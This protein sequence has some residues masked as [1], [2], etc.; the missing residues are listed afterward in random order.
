[1]IGPYYIYE[2][3]DIVRLASTRRRAV[4]GTPEVNRVYVY[5]TK[6]KI[7]KNHKR[8]GVL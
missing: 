7:R 1:M 4:D 2:R 8:V 3:Y 6:R 5:K